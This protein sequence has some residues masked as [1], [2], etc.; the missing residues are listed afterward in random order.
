MNFFVFSS[1]S[2]AQR[3]RLEFCFM[4]MEEE[5]PYEAKKL[6]LEDLMQGKDCLKEICEILHEKVPPPFFEEVTQ[7]SPRPFELD[8]DEP[9]YQEAYGRLKHSN[10]AGVAQCFVVY[11]TLVSGVEDAMLAC[12]EAWA[13]PSSFISLLLR[14]FKEDQRKERL[15]AF[16]LVASWI[17]KYPGD[18]DDEIRVLVDQEVEELGKIEPEVEARAGELWVEGKSRL[19][20][21]PGAFLVAVE[22][23]H[24]WMWCSHKELGMTKDVAKMVGRL[25]L[26]EAG[27]WESSDAFLERKRLKFSRED[28]QTFNILDYSPREVARMLFQRSRRSFCA[29]DLRKELC[30]LTCGK[31]NSYEKNP[32]ISRFCSDVR[33]VRAGVV[34]LILDQGKG[35][36]TELIGFFTDVCVILIDEYKCAAMG[37]AVNAGLHNNS[38][39]RLL[40]CVTLEKERRNELDRIADVFSVAAGRRN[41]RRLQ[42]NY[43]CVPHLGMFLID[44]Q[45][46]N[47]S[48]ANRVEGD[49]INCTKFFRYGEFILQLRQFQKDLL[50]NQ[51]MS[52]EK[53]IDTLL[54]LVV[55]ESEFMSEG[56]AL[57]LSLT[58]FPMGK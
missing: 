4:R 50:G 21:D 15:R 3:R 42:K 56:D 44:L 16:D 46:L 38:V 20:I 5:I 39:L 23:V 10:L 25:M 47:D 13:V 32:T 58:M 54:E 8:N 48:N 9:K 27:S 6:I 41:L 11:P 36:V 26:D 22:A 52:E 28:I 55:F 37:E 40:G 12:I 34:H 35:K 1:Y 57:K 53:E 45:F 18:F 31:W 51:E 14:Y 24:Y 49:L 17:E 7:L 19:L 43:G 2:F 30:T 33:Q 29:M